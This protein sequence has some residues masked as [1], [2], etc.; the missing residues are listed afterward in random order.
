MAT[1]TGVMIGKQNIPLVNE[2]EAVYHVAYFKKTE[3]VIESVEA[4][5]LVFNISGG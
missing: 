5:K 2:G 3:K 4:M 1:D